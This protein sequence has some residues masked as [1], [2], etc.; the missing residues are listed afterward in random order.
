[1][2]ISRIPLI[3]LF[4]FE[5]DIAQ[6][7][8]S[9]LSKNFTK[10]SLH[11]IAHNSSP[12][13]L[14]GLLYFAWLKHIKSSD[15]NKNMESKKH[16]LAPTINHYSVNTLLERWIRIKSDKFMTPDSSFL[17]W[18]ISY[19]THGRLIRRKVSKKLHWNNQLNEY[20]SKH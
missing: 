5:G 3:S 10:N 14:S 13:I 12:P 1:M 15:L 6:S 8:N 9:S 17:V 18:Y 7:L 4:P 2:S 20:L 16:L 19:L 11:I